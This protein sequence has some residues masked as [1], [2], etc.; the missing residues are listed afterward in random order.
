MPDDG[1][2]DAVRRAP[3]AGCRHIDTADMSAI[4]ALNQD[5][6]TDA[7]PDTFDF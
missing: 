1:A 4:S 6:R 2:A 3:E 5:L 7:D